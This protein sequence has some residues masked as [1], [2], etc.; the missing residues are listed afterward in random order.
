MLAGL[1]EPAHEFGIL[2]VLQRLCETVFPRERAPQLAEG[3][4]FHDGERVLQDGALCELLQQLRGVVPGSSRYSPARTRESAPVSRAW[5]TSSC[6]W[7]I[8]PRR[9]SSC[10]VTASG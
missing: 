7:S 1:A 2:D 3:P 10:A 6:G 4:A 9:A 5:I 8:Q